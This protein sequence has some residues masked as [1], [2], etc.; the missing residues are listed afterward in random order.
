[1][2]HSNDNML[3]FKIY[4]LMHDIHNKQNE[5]ENL[6]SANK[7]KEDTYKEMITYLQKVNLSLLETIIEN[8]EIGKK[9]IHRG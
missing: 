9:N 5:I 4:E 6:K 7:S 8:N 2:F 3:R 1:M